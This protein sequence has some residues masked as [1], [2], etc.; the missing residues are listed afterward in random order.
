M[1]GRLKWKFKRRF[2][3]KKRLR[4]RLIDNRRD[5]EK[6]AE[7]EYDL[8]ENERSWLERKFKDRFRIKLMERLIETQKRLM[9]RLID[10]Q[11]EADGKAD[12][13]VERS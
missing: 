8:Y 11:K 13:D 5:M 7:R 2:K 4:K 9:E 12:R 10:M 6:K 3:F 1:S